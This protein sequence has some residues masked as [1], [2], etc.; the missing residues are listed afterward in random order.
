MTRTLWGGLKTY[1]YSSLIGY[2]KMYPIVNPCQTPIY[3]S[4][5]RMRNSSITMTPISSFNIIDFMFFSHGIMVTKSGG[6]CQPLA[7][8]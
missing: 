6:H 4:H 3:S 2:E 8:P 5:K 1:I 7:G